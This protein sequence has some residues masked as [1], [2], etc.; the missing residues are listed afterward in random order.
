MVTLMQTLRF[1]PS[2]R[3]LNLL[4][5]NFLVQCEQSKPLRNNYNLKLG[6]YSVMK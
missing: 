3:N 4:L 2:Y 5:V 1:T 6:L